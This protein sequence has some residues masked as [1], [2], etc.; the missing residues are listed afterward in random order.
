MRLRV[1]IVD[2]EPHAISVLENY[3]ANFAGMEIVGRCSNAIQAFQLLQQKGVD[4]MFLD[5]EMPGMKG[6]EMLKSLKHPPKVIFTT[7]YSEYALEGFELNAVDYLLKPISLERFLRAIDKIYQLPAAKGLPQLTHEAPV[8]DAASYIYLKVDR[9]TVKINIAD[10]LWIES[11]RDYVK[12]VVADQ[13]YISRQKISLL[14]EMLPEHKFVRIHR[15]FIV[16]V[17]KINSFYSFSIDVGGH[18]LPIGRNYKL[19]VQKKLKQLA[20]T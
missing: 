8:S 20:T 18:E 13:V 17:A 1:L 16:A 2:D 6:T 19:E 3:L 12:V 11:L 14:E 5:I 9:R 4:L 10:I 15:S 7:A